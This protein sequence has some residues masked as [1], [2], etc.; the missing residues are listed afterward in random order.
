MTTIPFLL[1]NT[2]WKIRESSEV[3]TCEIWACLVCCT[4]SHHK[5]VMHTNYKGCLVAEHASLFPSPPPSIDVCGVL[6]WLGIRMC[7]FFNSF[8]CC[9]WHATGCFRWRFN[10]TSTEKKQHWMFLVQKYTISFEY[11]LPSVGLTFMAKCL[12]I[13]MPF[14]TSFHFRDIIVIAFFSLH[15]SFCFHSIDYY[16]FVRFSGFRPNR[17]SFSMLIKKNCSLP[18]ATLRWW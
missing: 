12:V 4:F 15:I 17:K 14:S 9:S 13:Y 18:G 1:A 11:W 2:R 6:K 10:G 5:N 16:I 7:S 8:S 3:V